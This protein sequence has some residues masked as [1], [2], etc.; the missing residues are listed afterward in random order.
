MAVEKAM[1]P[2]VEVLRLSQ[3]LDGDLPRPA[4]QI[5]PA[6]TNSLVSWST[7]DNGFVLETISTLNSTNWRT[8]TSLRGV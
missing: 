5:A 2:S 8:E 7:N 1:E 6:G 3:V 4:L